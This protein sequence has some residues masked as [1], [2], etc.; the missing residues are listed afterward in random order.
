MASTA[1]AK[2]T[3]ISV[4]KVRSVIDLVRGLQVEVA[5]DRLRFLSSPVAGE[6]SKLLRS[7]VANAENEMMTQSSELVISEIY[8]DEGTRLKRFRA[9][10]RGRA[11]R[12]TKQNSHIT[13]IVDQQEA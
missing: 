6:V 9:A 4:T 7:A 8:A 2:N 5:L 1:T 11:A 13:V 3:G 12:I 10:A